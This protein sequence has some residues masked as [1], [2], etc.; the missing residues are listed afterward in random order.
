MTAL[1]PVSV[2]ARSGV[3]RFEVTLDVSV[4]WV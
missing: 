1:G 3:L 2:G 4:P